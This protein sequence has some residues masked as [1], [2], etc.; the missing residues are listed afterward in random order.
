MPEQSGWDFQAEGY[1]RAETEIPGGREMSWPEEGDLK[2]DELQTEVISFAHQ[3]SLGI[4]GT[5]VKL[6]RLRGIRPW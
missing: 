4:A 6:A 2:T 1:N 5:C 3:H